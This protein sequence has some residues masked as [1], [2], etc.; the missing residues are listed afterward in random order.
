MEITNYRYINEEFDF[1]VDKMP[2][3]FEE[4]E[5]TGD[6]NN[7]S[8]FLN[9]TNNFDE[10]WGSLAKMEISWEKKDRL[11]TF[12]AKEVQR[13]INLYNSIKVI[14]KKKEQSW[15]RSHEFTLLY[16]NR[17]KMVGRKFYPEDSIHGV[18]YCDISNRIFNIHTAVIKDHYE[19]FKSYILDAYNTFICH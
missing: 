15:I 7:G 4:V 12:H 6:K 13:A 3:W 8:V 16:G 10:N 1:N 18:F 5:S 17:M 11:E 14:I 19:G 2:I 9:T